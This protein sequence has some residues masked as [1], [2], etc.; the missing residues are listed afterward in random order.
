MNQNGHTPPARLP[1]GRFAAIAVSV[2]GT[3]FLIV[4]MTGILTSGKIRPGLQPKPDEAP[5][6]G[7]RVAV[8]VD[9]IPLV[10]EAVGTVA[11]RIVISVSAQVMATVLEV[12]VSAG[13]RVQK[14]DRLIRLDQRDLTARLQEAQASLQASRAA[15][16]SAE[17]DFKRFSALVERAAVTQ[18]EFEDART[19][20]TLEQSRLHASEQA[21]A[22]ARVALDHTEITS[23][24][25]GVVV[26]KM[27]NAGDLAVPGKPLLQLQDPR[28][29]RLEAAVAEELA[30]QLAIGA[31]VSVV[32]DALG[33]TIETQ[34]DELIPR[35]DPLTRTMSV[36][37]NLPGEDGL[38]P[39][40]FGRLRFPAG[41]IR[42]LS[43]PNAA[44]RRVGQLE[45]V[46]V[47][48][49]AGVRSRH[50]Q[51]G[52]QRGDRVEVLSGLTEG[53]TILLPTDTS[54]E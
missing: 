9:E 20:F 29:L 44:V 42:S 33:K 37:A 22:Q 47:V 19:R 35:A 31:P 45:T 36:R 7:A 53:E 49:E 23:P 18:K 27:V 38:Q 12:D 41:S 16:A 21:V 40:M 54:H 25:D 50:V 8:Q 52:A 26:E 24:I 51:T 14:G 3:L 32:V 5:P 2:A 39:G 34:I 43:I 15:L 1:K 28:Q 48:T 10:R 30:P 6:R 11:S 46:L 17:A 13:S 4:W